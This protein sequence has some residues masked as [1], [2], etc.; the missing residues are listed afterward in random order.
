MN[1][2]LLYYLWQHRLYDMEGLATTD[3]EP[4]SVI[5]PGQRNHDSGP[6]FGHARVQ[7]GSLQWAGN[8][9]IHVKTSDWF[10]HG[11]EQ[12]AAFDKLILHVVY[13]HDLDKTPGDAPIL[14]LKGRIN[15][16]LL[17]RY[18]QL[19]AAMHWVHCENLIGEVNDLT[20]KITLDRMAVERLERK[21]QDIEALLQQ[22]TGNW[23]ETMYQLTARN[24]GLRANRDT[25]ELLAR[26]LPQKLI[27]KHKSNLM[28]I[29]ALLFGQ[30]GLLQVV[31]EPDEYVQQLLKEYNYLQKLYRLTP[32]QA[33]QW[34]FMRMRPAAFPTLRLAQFAVLLH[35]SS[36]LFSKI[37][38]KSDIKALK[39]L[40]H[41][42]ASSYWETHYRFGESSV[43]RPKE[44]GDS[45]RQLLLI[46]LVAPMLFAYG[47][48]KGDQNLRDRALELLDSLKPEKNNVISRWAVIR[49]KAQTALESQAL[50]Q[51]KTEHCDRKDC[52]QCAIGSKLLQPVA[53]KLKNL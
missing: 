28:Q 1:E 14:E 12:D 16:A 38:E 30:A 11:H 6:D 48:Y 42:S 2:E 18:R 51:L 9:E 24:F 37:T 45:M 46:N 7:V 20:V 23:E 21:T 29:E 22:N 49:Y 43:K 4:L 15:D 53:L 8:V 50:L 34:K 44:L 25:F 32:L 5:H 17:D 27:S 41:V 10:K 39:E 33:H 36:H 31:D 3:G 52:L 26:S 19:Q 13:E 47:N 35:Q 40:F